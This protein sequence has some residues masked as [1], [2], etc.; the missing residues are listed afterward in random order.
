MEENRG[1]E[2]ARIGR[3][4]LEGKERRTSAEENVY[5]DA[6]AG[7]DASPQAVG[8]NDEERPRLG[9]Q[10]D[11]RCHHVAQ[12]RRSK[13]GKVH[14]RAAQK[15]VQETVSSTNTGKDDEESDS[16]AVREDLEGQ[17]G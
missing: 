16:K 4:T 15:P 11:K 6:G 5:G 7:K 13:T 9:G 1:D 17:G 3:A 14:F 2:E 12:E 10:K 8:P